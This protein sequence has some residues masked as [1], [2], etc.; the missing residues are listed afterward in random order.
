MHEFVELV[1]QVKGDEEI[2]K[3]ATCVEEGLPP[4]FIDEGVARLHELVRGGVPAASP[5]MALSFKTGNFL[6]ECEGKETWAAALQP[7]IEAGGSLRES[8]RA[9][10]VCCRAV[11]LGYSP[12]MVRENQ[13][14]AANYLKELLEEWRRSAGDP[15]AAE[16]ELWGL[17]TLVQSEIERDPLRT[18]CV[19]CG[20][21]HARFK[22]SCPAF[23]AAFD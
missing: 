15:D 14:Q 9:V 13:V 18:A 12:P 10:D 7:D 4:A 5:S 8:I 3:M 17:K 11:L 1:Y 23:T 19:R 20:T 22:K 21:K 2:S 6:M 16:A